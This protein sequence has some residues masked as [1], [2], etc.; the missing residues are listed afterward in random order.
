MERKKLATS[1]HEHKRI[2]PVPHATKV[3]DAEQGIVRSLVAITGNIDD[4]NDRIVSGAFTKTLRERGSRLRVLDGHN[5]DSVLSIVGKPIMVQEI[6]RDALPPEVLAEYPEASGALQADTQFLINTPEG[7]GV[8]DRL[9]AGAAYEWSIGYDAVSVG[10]EEAVRDGQKIRVRDLKEIRLW[11]YSVVCWGMN[12]GTATV[13]IKDRQGAKRATFREVFERALADIDAGKDPVA[14]ALAT[15]KEMVA[16]DGAGIEY[17]VQRLRDVLFGAT[18]CAYMTLVDSWLVQGVL[19]QD[20]HAGLITLGD[21]HFTH[22]LNGIGPEVGERQVCYYGANGWMAAEDPDERKAGRV[23]SGTNATAIVSALTTLEEVLR[24]AG[25]YDDD[26]EE[27]DKHAAGPPAGDGTPTDTDLIM[28]I[29][30]AQLDI[31][32]MELEEVR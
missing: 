1:P 2:A 7:K 3:L 26:D 21:E 13:A 9:A 15:Q 4:G 29:K 19:P 6:G 12:A 11:E 25:L 30:A 5:T 16:Y 8:Y 10:Y 22:I 27:D 20:E 17:P 14:I 31:E 28:R 24:R 23:L 32:L 18:R